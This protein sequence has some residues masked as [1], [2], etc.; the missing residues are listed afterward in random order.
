MADSR[1]RLLRAWQNTS[2]V[3][4]RFLDPNIVWVI[5]WNFSSIFTIQKYIMVVISPLK[6]TF[7]N[8]AFWMTQSF[9]KHFYCSC[10]HCRDTRFD[11]F[12]LFELLYFSLP[13]EIL[14]RKH[15]SWKGLFPPWIFEGF[16]GNS[17]K[18]WQTSVRLYQKT[19]S[20]AK[21]HRLVHNYVGTRG[22]VAYVLMHVIDRE[23]WKLRKKNHTKAP[24]FATMGDA[25][26][27]NYAHREIVI[28]SST[29]QMFILI[30]SGNLALPEVENRLFVHLSHV[31][32]IYTVCI[33][34]ESIVYVNFDLT[35]ME[36][37]ELRRT[38][39]F[40]VNITAVTFFAKFFSQQ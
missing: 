31:V 10:A 38:W 20:C 4:N 23:T 18:R 1:I 35:L 24:N 34:L 37:L 28:T 13:I 33:R 25:F 7:V 8:L 22:A 11:L 17:L 5:W 14:S 19:L 2:D 3:I 32:H 26:E 21:L 12:S 6:Q 39:I 29:V 30:G 9:P 36:P 40:K 15:V 27:S 16:R